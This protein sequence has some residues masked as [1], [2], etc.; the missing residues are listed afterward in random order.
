[1]RS[2]STC[3]WPGQ[4]ETGQSCQPQQCGGCVFA[5]GVWRGYPELPAVI[6]PVGGAGCYLC[7]GRESLF[8]ALHPWPCP[9]AGEG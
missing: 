9:G 3:C 6:H 4:G 1:M 8:E 2:P 5:T 7:S